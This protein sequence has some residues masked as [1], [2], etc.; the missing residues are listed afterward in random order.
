MA[1]TGVA[2]PPACIPAAAEAATAA[3]D[4]ESMSKLTLR[5]ARSSA[6]SAFFL[7]AR[8]RHGLSASGPEPAR[9]RG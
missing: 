4:I 7:G 9:K 2:G 3:M 5:C 6:A 1:A 8:L